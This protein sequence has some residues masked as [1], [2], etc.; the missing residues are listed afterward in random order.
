MIAVVALVVLL[1]VE[2]D[3]FK[4]IIKS[5]RNIP[6]YPIALKDEVRGLIII[7]SRSSNRFAGIRPKCSS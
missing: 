6:L 7:E 5:A 1:Q 2:P 4:T 3:S